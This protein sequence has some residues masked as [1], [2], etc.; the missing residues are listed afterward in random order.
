MAAARIAQKHAITFDVCK[1]CPIVLVI[2][3]GA[4]KMITII[5]YC[6]M[7]YFG[8]KRLDYFFEKGHLL[9]KFEI[10]LQPK[11]YFKWQT[12]IVLSKDGITYLADY[13]YW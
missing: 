8:D 1:I 6:F 2:I 5:S 7:W 12:I 3:P 4:P 11:A 9:S 10:F 13:L